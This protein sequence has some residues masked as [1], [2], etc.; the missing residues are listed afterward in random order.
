MDRRTFLTSTAALAAAALAPKELLAGAL[1]REREHDDSFEDWTPGM[2]H[3]LDLLKW[4]YKPSEIAYCSM[5]KKEVNFAASRIL[6]RTEKPYFRT[7]H[8][9]IWNDLKESRPGVGFMNP[10]HQARFLLGMPDPKLANEKIKAYTKRRLETSTGDEL[11][12]VL[13]RVNP[14][15]SWWLG[16]PDFVNGYYMDMKKD[17]LDCYAIYRL[18]HNLVD[19]AD[20]LGLGLTHMK[21]LKG[22]R[23]AI[24]EGADLPPLFKVAACNVFGNGSRFCFY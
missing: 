22:V 12:A 18:Q 17:E 20:M 14:N 13:R 24:I 15:L 21:P 3:C 5:Y 7:L 19:H 1:S 10:S 11:R 4:G 9:L 16:K 23:T 6:P 8:S 2:R